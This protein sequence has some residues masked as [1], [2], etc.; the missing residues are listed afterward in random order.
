MHPRPCRFVSHPC[1]HLVPPVPPLVPPPVGPLVGVQLAVPVEDGQ[2]LAAVGL[3]QGEALQLADLGERVAVDAVDERRAA[4][5][6]QQ[7]GLATATC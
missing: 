7:R 1:L 6:Q 4:V 5:H 3:V 2:P